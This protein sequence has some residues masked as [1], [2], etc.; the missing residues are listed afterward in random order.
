MEVNDADVKQIK[1]RNEAKVDQEGGERKKMIGRHFQKNGW[2]EEMKVRDRA[3]REE[4][5][6]AQIEDGVVVTWQ[7]KRN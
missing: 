1:K 2:S 6:R 7:K 3:E 4:V 5:K